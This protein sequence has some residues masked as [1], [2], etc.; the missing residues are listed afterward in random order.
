VYSVLDRAPLIRLDY[1]NDMQRAPISHWQFHAERGSLTHLLTLSQAHRPRAVKSPHTLSSLHFPVGGE[2][3]R[4]C[5][6]DLLQFLVQECGVDH[7]DNWM[8]AIDAGRENWR[9][10]QLRTVVR[11]LQQEAADVLASS[12]WTVTPPDEP[13]T[14]ASSILHQW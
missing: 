12:G 4:P 8:S 6:E 7:H 9:R 1:R 14:E 5:L 10:V 3:F 2:R 11:D 13:L